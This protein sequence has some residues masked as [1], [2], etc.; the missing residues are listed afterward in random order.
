MSQDSFTRMARALPS[1][2]KAE[3]NTMIRGLLKSWGVGDDEIKVQL[4]NTKDQLFV[5]K[6]AG[7]NLD[8]LGSNV[9]V[10]RDPALGIDDPDFQELIP[11][12]SFFPKQVR[13]TLIA[14]LDVFWG[15]GF[16]RPNIS[17][18]NVE[19][20]NFG[21]EVSLTGTVTFRKD[22][23]TISGTGTNFLAQVQVGDY[24]KPSASN[25]YAYQK[26]SAVI[27]DTT[28]E[29]S[30][31][32]AG[33]TQVNVNGELGPVRQLSYIAD[34]NEEKSIRFIPNAFEDLN[35]VTVAE[36]INFIN[37]NIE[38]NV[39]ITASEFIDPV[40]GSKLNIRTN[41]A[42]LSGSIQI[43]GGDANDP[44][45]LN[46]LLD[47]QT[48]TRVK[49]LEI[50]PNEIVVQIPSSVP[51]LRRS[52]R[53]SAHPRQDKT[54]I[55]SDRE[56]FDFSGLGAS[57]T[58]EVDIDGS[59]FTVILDHSEFNDSSKVT[60]EEVALQINEQ[61]LFLAAETSCVFDDIKRIYLR[62]T[63]GSSEF[64]ITG[65]T[66]N[67]ILNFPTTLNQDPDLIDTDFPSSYIFDPTGQ[68]FTVTGINSE[69]SQPVVAG[70][71]SSTLNLTNA[72]NFPNSPGQ[73]ILDFG[74]ST[75]EGPIFY[76]SRPNNST[77]LIDA[78]Y[79]FEES[80]A[81]GRKVNLISTTP[82]IPRLTGEDYP[83][84]VTGTEQAREAA[85]RLIRELLA[86]GVVIRFIVDFPE[87]LFECECRDC[88]PDESPDYRGALSGSDP[89]VF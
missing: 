8:R 64:Q 56:I 24:I 69:L 25:G 71:V 21:P 55:S 40:A 17:S 74:R 35:A 14:L 44:T 5:T 12:L 89:L 76:T 11:I 2:Y 42:G 18:G 39:L 73:F 57:S 75:Q 81:A 38:H 78:S 47:R 19:T 68:L 58:L 53:G 87:F 66:A 80:H 15:P 31:P 48:E 84:Y 49:V 33:D 23:R 28:L 9:G 26:V 37:T 50:N 13:K 41:T 20:Y 10:D 77:L 34:N 70:T 22:D 85:Q 36:L 45:R 83:F 72:A 67:S 51:V 60:C 79:T 65:G 62:T 1:F 6:A 52:L 86:A 16:T 61:L 63:E 32:W 43:T 82:S 46:F 7:N 3:V 59:P 29:L 27:D 4:K 30:L 88:G 54:I